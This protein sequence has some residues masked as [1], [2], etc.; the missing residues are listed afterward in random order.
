MGFWYAAPEG[1]CESCGKP[2]TFRQAAFDRK[3]IAMMGLEVGL[4]IGDVLSIRRCDIKGYCREGIVPFFGDG[5]FKKQMAL[6]MPIAALTW[7]G[8]A[9]IRKGDKSR[10][11]GGSKSWWVLPVLWDALSTAAIIANFKQQHSF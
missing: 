6:K 10:H 4:Q 1:S 9:Y 8:T 3:A 11:I 5:S 7:I 2:L